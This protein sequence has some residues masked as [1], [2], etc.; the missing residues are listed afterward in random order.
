MSD[1]LLGEREVLVAVRRYRFRFASEAQLQE[2]IE[3][4]LTDAELGFVR[5]E[6]LTARDRIDFLC[7]EQ[8]VGIEVKVD[9]ATAAVEQQLARYAES[10]RVG[11]LILITAC[12]R[13]GRV[14]REILGKPVHVVPTFAG[15]F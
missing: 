4:A 9:G 7:P 2:S 14:R 1:N 8:M 5:E 10:D 12:A 15:G 6:R 11:E 3:A 13:H